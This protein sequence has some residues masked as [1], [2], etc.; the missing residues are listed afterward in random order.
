MYEREKAAVDLVTIHLDLIIAVKQLQA[1]SDAL[2]R[3]LFSLDPRAES[4]F[5]KFVAEEEKKSVEY[6]AEVR[7]RREEIRS[8]IPAIPPNPDKVN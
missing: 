4:Y 1:G 6:L 3:T 2:R 8:T 5:V 7:R